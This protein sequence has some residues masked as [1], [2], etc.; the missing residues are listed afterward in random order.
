MRWIRLSHV[1][2]RRIMDIMHK[3]NGNGWWMMTNKSNLGSKAGKNGRIITEQCRS[4]IALCRTSEWK[5]ISWN[6]DTQGRRIKETV[7]HRAKRQQGQTGK[8]GPQT[9]RQTFGNKYSIYIKSCTAF[10]GSFQKKWTH[11]VSLVNKCVNSGFTNEKLTP[12]FTWC[13]SFICNFFFTF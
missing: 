12:A 7:C 10:F 3:D 11:F 8:L 1:D 4:I 2:T 9:S 5:F 6:I 13:V